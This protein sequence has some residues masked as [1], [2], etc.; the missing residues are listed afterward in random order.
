MRRW[1]ILILLSVPQAALAETETVHLNG[2]EIAAAD[3]GNAV[4]TPHA[5]AVRIAPRVKAVMLTAQ[6]QRLLLQRLYPGLKLSPKYKTDVVFVAGSNLAAGQ[7]DIASA[8]C[9]ATRRDVPAGDYFSREDF[10]TV[11]C[12]AAARAERMG[13]DKAARAVFARSD[14]PAFTYVGRLALPSSEPVKTG[15]PMTLRTIAGPVTIDRNVVTLQ[16]ARAGQRV[17][18]R[19]REGVVL[20]HPLANTAG[21]EKAGQ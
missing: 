17:F 9:Y 3:I 4:P 6:E 1:G 13:Y 2:R 5:V 7:T 11:P 20:A 19:T 18:V 15:T 10:A 14:V 8:R 21:D 16:P 12:D